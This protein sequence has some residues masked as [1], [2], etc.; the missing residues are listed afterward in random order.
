MGQNTL[1]NSD[2]SVDGVGTDSQDLNVKAMFH[3]VSVQRLLFVPPLVTGYSS[4]PAYIFLVIMHVIG[5]NRKL[6]EHLEARS[7]QLN[8]QVAWLW[9]N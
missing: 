9:R 8:H 5:L 7:V 1:K 4:D 2:M 6:F 3:F